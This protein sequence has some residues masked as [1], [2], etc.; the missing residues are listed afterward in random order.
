MYSLSVQGEREAE[1]LPVN[2]GKQKGERDYSSAESQFLTLNTLQS[3]LFSVQGVERNKLS[4]WKKE[5]LMC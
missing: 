3:E 1:F 5:N 4:D 2:V